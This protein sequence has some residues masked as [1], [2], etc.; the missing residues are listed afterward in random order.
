[1][2]HFEEQNDA[3][4]SVKWLILKIG[5]KKSSF[6]NGFFRVSEAFV[7]LKR[8]KIR[9]R[10]FGSKYLQSAALRSAFDSVSASAAHAKKR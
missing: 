5:M 8:S 1:M 6:W 10:F 7:S 3:F 2:R 9:A 4:W